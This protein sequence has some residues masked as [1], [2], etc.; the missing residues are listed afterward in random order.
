MSTRYTDQQLIDAI[1]RTAAEVPVGPL[2]AAQ[3]RQH[4]G[5]S[6]LTLLR[7]FGGW[8]QALAAADLAGRYGGRPVTTKMRTRPSQHLTDVQVLDELRRVARLA[9]R[10]GTVTVRDVA[11]HSTVLGK[12]TVTD[13]FGSWAAAVEAAGLQVSRRGRGPLTEQNLAANL[14]AVWTHLGRR[15]TQADMRRPPSQIS[16]EPYRKRYGGW[17]A[18]VQALRPHT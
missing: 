5:V 9:G 18:A 10:G 8:S 1:R 13:R 12:S 2:R 6:V 11:L 3:V 7:R 14:H 17:T 4:T 16:P 15:P